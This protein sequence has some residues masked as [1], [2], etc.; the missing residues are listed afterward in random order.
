MI[1]M[2][3]HTTHKSFIYYY[4]INIVNNIIINVLRETES[5]LKSATSFDSMDEGSNNST[6][7]I[8]N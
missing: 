3:P 8:I 1:K 2:K 6:R 5:V 4:Y 7:W